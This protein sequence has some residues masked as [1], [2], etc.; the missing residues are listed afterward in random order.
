[1]PN[2]PEPAREPWNETNEH[3]YPCPCGAQLADECPMNA[4]CARANWGDRD[5]RI[6]WE[7]PNA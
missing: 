3:H 5:P 2:R 7:W 4:I 6:P 1:M